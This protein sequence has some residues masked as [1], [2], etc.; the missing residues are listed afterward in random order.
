MEPNEVLLDDVVVNTN[1]VVLGHIASLDLSGVELRIL[2]WLMFR[3]DSNGIA[4]VSREEI[5]SAFGVGDT[6]VS[7]VTTKLKNHGLAWREDHK[8][9]RVN[10]HFAGRGSHEEW[11]RTADEL[12][13]DA[14]QILIQP[15]LLAA[16]QPKPPKATGQGRRH[17]RVVQ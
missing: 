8:R 13:A 15:E 4:R 14:P 2:F 16:A 11:Q 9:I 17:L 10:P 3:M 5:A 6:Y 1:S 7:K 12:P